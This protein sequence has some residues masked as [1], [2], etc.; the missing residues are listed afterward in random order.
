M[1]DLTDADLEAI[2]KR[3]EKAKE[4]WSLRVCSYVVGDGVYNWTMHHAEWY[5]DN[6][7]ALIAALRE[8]RGEREKVMAENRLLVEAWLAEHGQ[9]PDLDIPITAA[10]VERVKRLERAAV[11]LWDAVAVHCLPSALLD[12]ACAALAALEEGEG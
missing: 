10:E 12:L 8:A 7:P 4:E 5:M 6:L 1:T 2:E 11:L 9:L 3:C